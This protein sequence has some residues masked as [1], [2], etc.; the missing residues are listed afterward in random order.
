MAGARGAARVVAAVAKPQLNLLLF[1]TSLL[2]GRFFEGRARSALEDR[3]RLI[4]QHGIWGDR[5]GDMPT[6]DDSRLGWWWPV[7]DDDAN[8]DTDNHKMLVS[9]RHRSEINIETLMRLNVGNTEGAIRETFNRNN[10]MLG[11]I[12][13]LPDITVS[14]TVRDRALTAGNIPHFSVE[15]SGLQDFLFIESVEITLTVASSGEELYKNTISYNNG[16][17]LQTLFRGNARRPDITDIRDIVHAERLAIV[18]AADS[19]AANAIIRRADN[20]RYYGIIRRDGGLPSGQNRVK[21]KVSYASDSLLPLH[22][23]HN[24]IWTTGQQ[25]GPMSKGEHFNER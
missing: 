20:P 2:L 9:N 13:Q 12:S 21:I 22:I 23:E 15:V 7:L 17:N 11:L 5:N 14:T 8:I 10:Y 16:D 1:M 4:L 3:V 24:F 25:R 19:A 6:D 18:F